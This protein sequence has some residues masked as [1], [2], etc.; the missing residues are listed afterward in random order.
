MS[1]TRITPLGV[2][3]IVAALITVA[4]IA[5]QTTDSDQVTASVTVASDPVTVTGLQNLT[6]GTHFASEGLV[7]NE[8]DAE[9]GI[10][11]PVGSVVDI[12]LTTLPA[13]LEDGSGNTVPVTYGATSLALWCDDGAGNNTMV[14]HTP[15]QGVNIGCLL[16]NGGALAE[17][18]NGSGFDGNVSI[19]LTGAPDGT[20][21]AFIEL[22]ATIR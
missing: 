20:Y 7:T 16:F 6:F 15:V 2:G 4:P 11:G 9:W 21:T 13:F 8:A 5:A 22:T 12:A 14:N 10:T 3:T 18:G 17:L 1:I 19:D